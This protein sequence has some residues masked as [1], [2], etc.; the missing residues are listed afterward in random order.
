MIT[1]CEQIFYKTTLQK[2]DQLDSLCAFSG[3]TFTLTTPDGIVH[4]VSADVPCIGGNSGL[5][6]CG[7][8]DVIFSDL[9]PYTVSAADV[10]DGKITAIAVY[11]GGVVHDSSNDSLGFVVS[12]LRT[13]LVAGCDTTTTVTTSSSTTSTTTIPRSVCA[14]LKIQAASQ[15][16]SDQADCEARAL[17]FG[18]SVR[19]ECRD[20]AIATFEKTWA[21]IER[22]R[23]CLTMGDQSNV[24]ALV[25]SCSSALHG[26][27]VP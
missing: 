23:D 3:G 20:S 19:Q 16:G 6:G 5:E 10:H 2:P 21:M 7:F 9:I 11:S 26:V 15:L 4:T 13:T 12:V 25:G 27:L 24:E 14:S 18:A 1:G 22:R 8:I 17:K